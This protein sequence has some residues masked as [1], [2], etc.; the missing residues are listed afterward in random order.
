MDE[1]VIGKLEDADIFA[2][3][4][5]LLLERQDDEARLVLSEL[6]EADSIPRPTFNSIWGPRCDH[7]EAIQPV[8]NALRAQVY[9]RD[10]WGCRYCNRKLVVPGMLELLTTVVPGFKGLLP[11]HHMPFGRTE[12]AVER[13][14][15]NVDHVHAVANGGAWLDTNNHVTACTPCNAKKSNRTGWVPNPIE[16]VTHDWQGLVPAYRPLAARVDSIRRYHKNLF[17]DLGI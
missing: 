9:N 16:N 4:V 15:P 17:R 2:R 13:V 14:Y 1:P 10:W 5:S 11:G 8:S 3:A 6:P 12:P 7:R